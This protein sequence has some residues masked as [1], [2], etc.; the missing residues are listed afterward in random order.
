MT[1]QRR[2]RRR[3]LTDFAARSPLHAVGVWLL[4]SALIALLFLA[5]YL[6]IV[7]VLVPELGDRLVEQ[8]RTR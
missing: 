3:P 4:R 2:S 1:V 6:V 7:N 8:I 5:A